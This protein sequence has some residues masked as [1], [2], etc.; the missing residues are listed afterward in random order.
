[1]TVLVLTCEEDVTAD[2]VVLHLRRRGVPV[3][4]F[5]PADFPGRADLAV[6]VTPDGQVTGHLATPGG[7]VALE[8]IR[9]VW[10]RRPGTPGA[11]VSAE[12]RAWITLE[13]ERA[14][15]GAL[16]ATGARW[17]N[18]P[19]ALERSRHKLWQLATAARAGLR[20]PDTLV[21]T[22]PDE[23]ARFQKG[24]ADAGSGLVVKSVSGRHPQNPPLTLPTAAV[25]PDADFTGVA[26][27]AT[28][29]QQRV[30]KRTDLR[31]T[32]VGDRYFPAY[33]TPRT[34]TLDWRFLPA[35]ASTWVAGEV[36]GALR[37]AVRR[38]LQEAQ[39]A[40]AAFD[41]AI[42]ER[43]DPWFLEANA[44]GQFLFAEIETGMPMTEAI[45]A[46]LAIRRE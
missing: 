26:A 25:P 20:V 6:R 12:Q 46:W 45:A 5:D 7:R 34:P 3:L 31:L 42:D 10:V 11:H 8:E 16:R 27:C 41:F 4:R 23:A 22:D 32:V 18:D 13:C 36:D 35:D 30:P 24:Y 1:M 21:T 2:A 9:S 28:C 40:Y 44:G 29:L 38:Y 15:W 39:L 14:L 33:V 37:A 19:D 43:G 17:M